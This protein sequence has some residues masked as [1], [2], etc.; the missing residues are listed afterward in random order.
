VEGEIGAAGRLPE[1]EQPLELE[2][3]LLDRSQLRRI[4]ARSGEGGAFHLDGEAHLEHV[5]GGGD[6]TAHLGGERANGRGGMV[7]GEDAGPLAGLHQAVGGER[8]QRL[9]DHRA[10]YAE[11]LGEPALG[12]QLLAGQDVAGEQLRAQGFGDLRRKLAPRRQPR[13]RIGCHVS[14]P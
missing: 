7:G 9:A 14:A 11:A 5:D 1:P 6:A 4:P 8:R 12:R 10:R 3:G 13:L 2:E